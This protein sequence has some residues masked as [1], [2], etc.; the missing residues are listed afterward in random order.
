MS[1]NPSVHT[2]HRQRLKERFCREGLDNFNE[3]NVLELMLFYC[4]QR[5]DTNPL[6]HRL[7]E[8]FGKLSNVL[9]ADREELMRVEGVTENIAVYLS[10]IRQ[11]NRFYEMNRAN[12]EKVLCSISECA[13][14]MQDN[15]SGCS[16]ET[17]YILCMDAKCKALC[18]RKV[19]EGDIN[20]TPLSARKV[21]ETAI[22]SKATSVVVAHNHPS[23]IALPSVEDVQVTSQI[24]NALKA[25]DV[26]LVDH[27]IFGEKDL[28]TGKR[29]YVS[30]V[31][32]KLYAPELREGIQILGSNE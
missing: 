22:L 25:V 6:A 7:L 17:V 8:Y 20:S 29:D 13:E 32:S 14:Y 11:V 30:L 16:L 23:G 21:V 18:C 27:L 28:K 12:K 3:I 1:A 19:S 5:R 31:Q 9:E 4:V 24:G 15:F 10:M 2:G 26:I